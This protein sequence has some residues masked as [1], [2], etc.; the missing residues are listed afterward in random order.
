MKTQISVPIRTEQFLELA[1][2]LR[3]NADPRDPVIVV[4]EAIDYW[5]Q[6]AGWKP[7]LLA[8][9]DTRGYQWKNLF[10]P[11]GTQIRM[12]YKGTFHYAKVEGDQ[13]IYQGTSISPASLANKIASSSR[14]AWRDLWIKRPE[15]KEW[16]LANNC[17]RD[18]ETETDKLLAGLDAMGDS[19]ASSE[20]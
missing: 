6:N 15:D 2:F 17:R 5:I 16:T 8:Q 9:S 12:P 14:N 7:E 10:L 1:E 3:T 4:T 11:D 13:I 20:T 18:T 19:P